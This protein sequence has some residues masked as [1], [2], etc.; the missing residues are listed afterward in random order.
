MRKCHLYECLGVVWL[1]VSRT[2]D[3]GVAVHDNIVFVRQ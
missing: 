3:I 1:V 2:T